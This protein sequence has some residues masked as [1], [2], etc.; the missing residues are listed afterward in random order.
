MSL[1]NLLN[2]KIIY[3]LI[4]LIFILSVVSLI[5]KQELR[6]LEVAP[7]ITNN[8]E[9][10]QKFEFIFNKTPAKITIV[11]SPEFRFEKIIDEKKVVLVPQELL[12]Q[13]SY[14]TLNIYFKEKKLYQQTFKTRPGTETEVIQEETNFTFSKYPLIDFL[15]IDNPRYHLTYVDSLVFKVTIKQG[16]QEQ[17]RQE[18]VDW[19]S[20]K[21]IDPDT[22]RIIFELK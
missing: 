22:H 11:V 3:F 17:I 2:K 20:S 9:L 6:L 15:P 18:I 14:Y 13:N 12:K 4:A 8:I 1:L 5:L 10:N 7:A 21:G 16:S 19:I